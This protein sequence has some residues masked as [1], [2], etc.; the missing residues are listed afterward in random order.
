MA[1]RKSEHLHPDI[2]Q[3]YNSFLQGCVEQGIDVLTTCTYRSGEEQTILYAK[4]RTEPGRIVTKA[5]AGESKHN[6]TINGKPASKAFDVVPIIDG[7]PMWWDGH[8]AWQTLGEIGERCG[9]SWAGRWKFKEYPHF[10]IS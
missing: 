8:P 5:K 1:S 9:L 4:G 7:K 3:K 10:E 6:Y 2:I